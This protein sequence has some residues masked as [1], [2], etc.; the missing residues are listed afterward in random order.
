MDVTATLVGMLIGYV[1]CVW[2][3]SLYVEQIVVRV[4]NEHIAAATYLFVN[5]NTKETTRIQLEPDE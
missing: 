2:S 5:E 4:I 3:L 1:L